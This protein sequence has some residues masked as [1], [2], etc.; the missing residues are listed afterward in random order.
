MKSREEWIAKAK[1]MFNDIGIL[2]ES[3]IGRLV[4]FAEDDSDYYY[5]VRHIQGNRYLFK[6]EEGFYTVHHSC[7]GEFVSL[8]N[9]YGE[10]Y[11]HMDNVFTMNGAPPAN[12]F[13]IKD[14]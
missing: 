12:T 5:I 3:E 6:D 13:I 8:K 11:T 14:L 10:R 4:G 1:S 9:I 2:H 7:V